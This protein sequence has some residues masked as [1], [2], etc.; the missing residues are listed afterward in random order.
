MRKSF[1][2]SLLLRI[3]LIAIV[4]VGIILFTKTKISL[5]NYNWGKKIERN[6]PEEL[7]IQM[8]P[9]LFLDK[10]K[11]HTLYFSEKDG[12]ML[13]HV[14]IY[15]INKNKTNDV[16]T[17]KIAEFSI[18]QDRVTLILRDGHQTFNN[19]SKIEGFDTL[20]LVMEI[21]KEKVIKEGVSR[22][23]LEV[24]GL[25]P[26]ERDKLIEKMNKKYPITKQSTGPNSPPSA[27]P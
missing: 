13:K 8:T 14:V 18:E 27:A 23:S 12:K 26:E 22:K 9:G 20:S 3:L 24:R 16:I 6:I 7:S 17:A 10:F 25:T 19:R 5:Q 21:D 1:A 15:P 4:I 11:K 2:F